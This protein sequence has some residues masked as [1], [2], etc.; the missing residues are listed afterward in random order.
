[1]FVVFD[2]SGVEVASVRFDDPT[3]ANALGKT[4]RS[5]K[6]IRIVSKRWGIE[7]P[8]SC[9][10]RVDEQ[11]TREATPNPNRMPE[12]PGSSSRQKIFQSIEPLNWVGIRKSADP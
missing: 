9:N 3:R 6:A 5:E 1:L 11:A 2:L 4:I 8:V 10:R 7:P 12:V